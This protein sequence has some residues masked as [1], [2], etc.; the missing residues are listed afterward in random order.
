MMRDC[1]EILATLGPK[2]RNCA[3]LQ[4][5]KNPPK[6]AGF[7]GGPTYAGQGDPYK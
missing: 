7:L 5:K 6:W 4:N 2:N 1:L 3:V